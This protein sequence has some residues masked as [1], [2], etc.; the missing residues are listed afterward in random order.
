M[1]KRYRH[2]LVR[3]LEVAR[4]I[5]SAAV[6]DAFL[7]VPR[8]VFLPGVADEHGIATVYRDEAYPTKTDEHGH[9]VSS[10]SQ[11]GIMASM[12][13]ELRVSPGHRVLE[14]GAGIVRRHLRDAGLAVG[15]GPRIGSSVG[16]GEA[17][18]GEFATKSRHTDGAELRRSPTTSGLTP[19]RSGVQGTIATA[20]EVLLN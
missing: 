18:S 11:P 3:Q 10:S 1:S 5:R 15:A 8:E 16:R 14:V 13:E 17:S 7:K 6:R 20:E 19:T 4:V 12:L 9:A 2:G